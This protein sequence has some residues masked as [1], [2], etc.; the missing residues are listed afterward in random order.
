MQSDEKFENP[1][2]YGLIATHDN[3][4]LERKYGAVLLYF[5]FSPFRVNVSRRS[6]TKV[7]EINH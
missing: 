2:L 4:C 3:V 5:V 6:F 1:N 7:I